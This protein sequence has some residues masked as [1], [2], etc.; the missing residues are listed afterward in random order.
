[1]ASF[2]SD[3]SDDSDYITG[4]A[5]QAIAVPVGGAMRWRQ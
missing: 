1:M 5:I 2:D 3:D 4:R